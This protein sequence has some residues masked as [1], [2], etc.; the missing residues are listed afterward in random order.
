[1]RLL[2]AGVPKLGPA[3]HAA[4]KAGHA[5]VIIDGTLIAID[6]VAK[7]RPF[8]SGKHKRHGMNLQVISAPDGRD[9]LGVRAAARQR[10]RPDPGGDLGD[11]PGAGCRRADHP[12]R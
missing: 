9:P 3:L 10:A 6:R 4:K 11:R 5:F 2:A 12:G 8:Y 1:V 7:D